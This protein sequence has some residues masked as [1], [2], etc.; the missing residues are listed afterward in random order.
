MFGVDVRVHPWFWLMTALMGWSSFQEGVLYLA[1]WIGCV[2]VSI[3]IHEYG[4][5]FMG[6]IFGTSGHIVLY[7]LGGLAVGS[8]QLYL[9]WQRILVSLAGSAAD[10]LFF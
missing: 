7:S 9:H 3:L 1:L 8:N 6:R 2:F 4:H 5:I 10:F